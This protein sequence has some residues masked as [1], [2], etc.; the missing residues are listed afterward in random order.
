MKNYNNRNEK[1]T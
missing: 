1:R